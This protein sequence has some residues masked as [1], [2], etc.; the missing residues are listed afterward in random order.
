MPVQFTV[1]DH[2]QSYPVIG[3]VH[4]NIHENKFQFLYT[5]Y[6]L[7]YK[8]QFKTGMAKT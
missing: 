7:A 8:R 6:R 3:S 4:I 1:S 2:Y 5:N